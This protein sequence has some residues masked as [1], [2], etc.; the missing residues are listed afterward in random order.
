MSDVHALSGAYA[1]DAVTDIERQQFERHLTGCEICTEEVASL[2]E[3]VSELSALTAEE[4][5][6]ELRGSVL[7][8]IGETRQLPPRVGSPSR[9]ARRTPRRLLV[10]AAAAAV[11]VGGVGVGVTRPWQDETGSGQV[12]SLADR[13][14]RADDAQR[15]TQEFEDG[16][17]ATV[18]RSPSLGRAV[19]VTSDMPPAPKGHSYVVWLQQ[20]DDMVNAGSMARSP[21][22]TVLLEGDAST[23]SAA[24]VTVETDPDAEDA[25]TDELVALF[26]F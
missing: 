8:A 5:P 24:G 7:A 3:A 23:A 17:K 15:V 10:A 2:R 25:T 11:V 22:Q 1:L 13:V 6:P 12:V 9:P 4:P 21:D 16:A 26:P 14:L 20:G 18:V 19:L